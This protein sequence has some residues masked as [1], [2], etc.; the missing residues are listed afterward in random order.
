MDSKLEKLD[1]LSNRLDRILDNQY[2]LAAEIK[3]ANDELHYIKVAILEEEKLK[4]ES[5]QI[6]EE[7]LSIAASKKD[8][9]ANTKVDLPTEK[10]SY[11]EEPEITLAN[12]TGASEMDDEIDIAVE[13][14]IGTKKEQQESEE[15][16]K[17]TYQKQTAEESQN[18]KKEYYNYHRM[19]SKP[20]AKRNMEKFIGENLISKIGVLILILGIAFGTKYSIDNNLLSPLARIISGY[21]SGL[22]LGI[23]S[24]ILRKKY[25]SLSAVLI[26]GSMA[27]SYFVTFSAYRFYDLIPQ[28]LAFGLMTLFTIFTVIAALSY[29]MQVIAHIGMIASYAIPF[30]LSDGS[31]RIGI[32]LSYMSIINIGLL[33]I[34][35]KKYWKPTTYMSTILSW[36]ILI[37]SVF[38]TNAG[39]G[40]KFG[41]TTLFFAIFYTS[42]LAYKAVRNEEYR[43]GFTGL[44]FFNH[45]IYYIIAALLLQAEYRSDLL[46]GIFALANGLVHFVV[47]AFLHKRQ[48]KDRVIIHLLAGFVLFFVGISIPL[49][50]DGNVIPVLWI[51]E[52]A[53]LFTLARKHNL[54]KYEIISFSLIIFSILGILAERSNLYSHWSTRA[55]TPIFNEYMLT[56]LLFSVAIGVMVYFAYKHTNKGYKTLIPVKYANIFLT[57]LFIV[58][59]YLL[60]SY[61]I[62]HYFKNVISDARE[63]ILHQRE[64]LEIARAHSHIWQIIYAAVFFSAL[65]IFN[66]K[67][68]HSS[69]LTSFANFSSAVVIVLFLTL[70]LWDISV[71]REM[72]LKL[73]GVDDIG[74]G[75]FN[76]VTRYLAIA[77]MIFHSLIMYKSFA[78]EQDFSKIQVALELF[79]SLAAV[80]TLTSEI[81]QHLDMAGIEE[82]YKFG[83]SIGWS[84]SAIMLIILGIIKG[85]S[86][87]RI[88]GLV[89]FSVTIVKLFLYDIS[90]LHIISKTIIMVVL[91]VLM[92]VTSYLYSRFKNRLFGNEGEEEKNNIDS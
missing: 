44:L 57:S 25:K 12:F 13:Q 81:I 66:N 88:F 34:S 84:V 29:N 48:I 78:R 51:A 49:A 89:L 46:N 65:N 11:S 38:S 72:Y 80:W 35:F 86:H 67:K 2:T 5:T 76:I 28:E 27:V 90:N 3:I 64:N 36:L 43:P 53:L 14:P 41:F 74:Y 83:I 52:A 59:V 6:I 60:F 91:G 4:L 42:M 17:N 18:T 40:L 62:T 73:N 32:M 37:I 71:L 87:L 55:I 24:F 70:G 23:F 82:T 30:L 8:D 26:S 77:I 22:T 21:I 7:T 31:G 50:F 47:A 9:I 69:N 58:S 19:P 79:V 85:K 56:G 63:L 68:I 39:F 45:I 15:Q 61:E 10:M 1:N 20:I 16:A 33:V 75:I 92:L 54:P